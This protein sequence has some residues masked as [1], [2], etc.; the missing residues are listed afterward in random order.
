VNL[1]SN[2]S[3]RGDDAFDELMEAVSAEE[4]LEQL[5]EHNED[6]DE[7]SVAGLSFENLKQMVMGKKTK[8]VTTQMQF[9][10]TRDRHVAAIDTIKLLKDGFDKRRLL[11][12]GESVAWS[13][14]NEEI[15]EKVRECDVGYVSNFLRHSHLLDIRDVDLKFESHAWFQYLIQQWME[16]GEF[17]ADYYKFSFYS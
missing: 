12:G 14:Y 8:M 11:I 4:M 15:L 5:A 1:S 3:T 2:I 9:V 16:S 10:K 17:N 6:I 7:Y 13:D